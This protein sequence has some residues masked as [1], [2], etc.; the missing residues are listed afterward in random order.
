MTTCLAQVFTTNP[1]Y[2]IALVDDE[3]RR[4]DREML[5]RAGIEPPPPVAPLPEATVQKRP[6]QR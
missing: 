6:W 3:V 1:G 4:I 5:R 2:T